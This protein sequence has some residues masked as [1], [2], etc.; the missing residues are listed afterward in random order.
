MKS[1]KHYCLCYLSSKYEAYCRF[2]SFASLESLWK[3]LTTALQ[4]CSL[5]LDSFRQRLQKWLKTQKTVLIVHIFLNGCVFC[6]FLPRHYFF[7]FFFFFFYFFLFLSFTCLFSTTN[8]DLLS[9]TYF[10]LSD[11]LS[12]HLPCLIL[13]FEQKK[14]PTKNTIREPAAWL[15]TWTFFFPNTSKD[16][17]FFAW[18]P[19]VRK[20]T[21]NGLIWEKKIWGIERSCP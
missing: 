15:W 1:I 20:N 5:V 19:Y 21:R 13:C 10:Q 3:N 11:S 4:K 16:S 14:V 2:S 17:L 8:T 9:T 12:I 18:Y 7:H 6:R